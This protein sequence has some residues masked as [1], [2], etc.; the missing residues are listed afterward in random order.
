MTAAAAGRPDS[1]VQVVLRGD[2][3]GCAGVPHQLRDR[4][5][6]TRDLRIGS[7]FAPAGLVGPFI[8]YLS[9]EGGRLTLEVRDADDRPLRAFMFSLGA[10]RRL[11]KD[12]RLLVESYENAMAEGHAA[13]VQAIDM[14]RRGLHDEGAELLIARL[15]GKIELDFETARRLFT[16]VCLLHQRS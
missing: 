14:G 6:A 16:L 11:I 2:A 8:L 10:F 5:Q 12:Y 15:R 9:A 7:H 13:R 3:A 4:E 1:L